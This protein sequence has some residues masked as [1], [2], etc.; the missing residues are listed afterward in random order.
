MD[1]FRLSME[2]VSDVQHN[3]ALAKELRDSIW[4]KAT[5]SH[6]KKDGTLDYSQ[7]I[8]LTVK[9]SVK[10]VHG[11]DLLIDMLSSKELK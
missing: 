11:L 4:E 1:G 6:A 8:E 7:K 10:A 5:S 9:D 3:I 2:R